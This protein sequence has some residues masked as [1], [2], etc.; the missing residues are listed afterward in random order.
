MFSL[1]KRQSIRPNMA[2]TKEHSHL[3]L[4]TTYSTEKNEKPGA[5]SH[6]QPVE[7]WSQKS[8][9]KNLNLRIRDVHVFI[10]K[11]TSAATILVESRLFRKKHIALSEGKVGHFEV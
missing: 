4:E 10:K 8:A 9:R 5:V 7:E 11:L 2:I 3:Q 1:G 6:N